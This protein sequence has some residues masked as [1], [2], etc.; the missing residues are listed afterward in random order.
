[1]WH[2]LLY[3]HLSFF[4]LFN[5]ATLYKVCKWRY[6]Y[7]YITM[8]MLHTQSAWLVT[9]CFHT[10][11]RSAH[12]GQGSAYIGQRS[13]LCISNNLDRNRKQFDQR[14]TVHDGTLKLFPIETLNWT[15]SC[16]SGVQCIQLLRIVPQKYIAFFMN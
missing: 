13:T 12:I 8:H 7:I 15:P 2:P 4:F 1:M 11:Q 6:I 3:G 5:G 16:S 10:G 9:N 14:N